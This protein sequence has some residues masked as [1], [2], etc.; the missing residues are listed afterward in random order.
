VAEPLVSIEDFEARL[1][2]PLV[3]DE[4]RRAELLLQDASD[5]VREVVAPVEI[6]VP[7][8]FVVRQLV[9]DLAGRVLNNPKGIT[10]ENI[11]DYSYSLSRTS[12]NGMAL[13]PAELEWL[14]KVLGLSSIAS[15][16]M[17]YGLDP[18]TLREHTPVGWADGD[19]VT[20]GW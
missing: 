12:V 7:P 6:P 13:M 8:P 16:H 18:E 14:F 4:R 10:T 9:M 19:Q 11:G 3:G 15:V 2:E 17:S 1:P 20:W 5:L